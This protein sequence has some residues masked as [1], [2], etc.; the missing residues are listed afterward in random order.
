ML[1]HRALL[2]LS[3]PNVYSITQVLQMA[4]VHRAAVAL[5]VRHQVVT[6]VL[7]AVLAALAVRH[8]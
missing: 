3:L 1:I 4:V 2:S 5:A 8:Y 6:A 7:P